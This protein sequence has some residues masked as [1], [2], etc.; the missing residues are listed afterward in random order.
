MMLDF[1]RMVLIVF[2][3]WRKA[4]SITGLAANTILR[5]D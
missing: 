4:D 1:V 3:V 2:A 5:F